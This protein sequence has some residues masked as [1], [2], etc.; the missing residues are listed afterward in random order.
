MYPSFHS[1]HT[2]NLCSGIV[3]LNAL[4]NFSSL[5]FWIISFFLHC[6]GQGT[7]VNWC[8]SRVLTVPSHSQLLPTLSHL[9]QRA[10]TSL[11]PIDD[12]TFKTKDA[13]LFLC[14]L[15]TPVIFKV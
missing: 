13:V 9:T 10:L 4:L 8:S 12:D 15:L 6:L 11:L 1:T 3:L 7:G 5:F 2:H 14:G